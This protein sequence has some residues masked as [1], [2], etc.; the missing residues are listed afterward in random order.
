MEICLILPTLKN[1]ED[2][3]VQSALIASSNAYACR[4]LRI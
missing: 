1:M 3:I 4:N 2:C